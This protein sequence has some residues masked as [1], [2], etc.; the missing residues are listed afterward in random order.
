MNEMG[1]LCSG[2]CACVCLRERERKDTLL[3]VKELDG[4]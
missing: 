1:S 3:L 4:P 2:C